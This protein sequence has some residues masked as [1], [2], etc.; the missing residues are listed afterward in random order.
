MPKMPRD[1][2][3]M[4]VALSVALRATC[5]R[6]HVGAVIVCDDNILSTGFNGAPRG[7]PSCDEV[8]HLLIDGHCVRTIHA[9]ANALLAAGSNLLRAAA[10]RAEVHICEAQFIG[11]IVNLKK[12]VTLYTTTYP[13][14]WCM[15]QAIQCGVGRI[16][17][18]EEYTDETHNDDAMAYAR[19]AG[20]VLGI[21]IDAFP[22]EDLK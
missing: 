18:G 2:Y 20:E 3:Y 5:D 21:A 7:L 14:M 1:E 12:V 8:G 10:A 19:D 13:C 15:K 4:R 6:R 11:E 16:V 22:M 17:Y 9:E